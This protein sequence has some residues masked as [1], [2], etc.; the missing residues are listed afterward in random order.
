MTGPDPDEPL[1]LPC[2]T[3]D[4]DLWFAESSVLLERA[5]ELCRGCPVRAACLA[6]ALARREPW[7]VWGGDIVADGVVLAHKRGRGRPRRRR[8]AL[9]RNEP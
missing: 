9:T 7:G 1:S 6:G 3:H 2:R 5:K 4:P 8:P